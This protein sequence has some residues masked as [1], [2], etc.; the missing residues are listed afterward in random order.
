ML[1]DAKEEMS[2]RKNSSKPSNVFD[3]ITRFNLNL[4]K[5]SGIYA[6]VIQFNESG[7]H[8]CWSP[9]WVKISQLLVLE[10][11][12]LPALLGFPTLGASGY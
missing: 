12:F 11:Y 9:L 4:L 6:G 8:K 3:Q 1:C 7:P 10:I 2:A 5:L